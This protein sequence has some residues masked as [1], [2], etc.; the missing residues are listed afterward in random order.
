MTMCPIT[1]S[2]SQQACDMSMPIGLGTRVR[3]HMM[4]MGK[5][6]RNVKNVKWHVY[7]E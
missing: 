1:L 7:Q 4:H 6:I 3:L 2:D 5:H